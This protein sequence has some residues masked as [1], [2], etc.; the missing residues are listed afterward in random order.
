M[1]ILQEIAGYIRSKTVVDL[2]ALRERFPGRSV[3]SFHRDLAKLK[4]IT[5]YTDN[6]RYYTLPDI[7]DYNEHG[8]WRHG[9]IMFSINSTAKETVR[10]LICESSSGLSH[11]ELQGILGIRLY[12]PLKALVQEEAITSV[13]D[14]NKL[15]FFSGNEAISERQRDNRSD[16][17]N[18]IA[19]HPFN[20]NTTID[21]LLAVF[22]EN[23][24]TSEDAYRFLKSCKYPH[25]TLKEVVEIF[26]YYKLPGKKN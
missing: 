10:K 7:P 14:G 26:T 6:S 17:A 23:K 22:M 15:V 16:I 11:A 12:N 24:S 19:E 21:V 8:L 13:T 1:N 20:L 2:N 3:P 4:C 25:I 5:S 9:S 18:A